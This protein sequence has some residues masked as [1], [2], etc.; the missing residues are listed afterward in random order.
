MPEGHLLFGDL[1]NNVIRK[2]DPAEGDSI[3]RTRTGYAAADVPPGVAMGS[4]GMTLD[5]HGR[6]TICESGNRRVT[7]M[8]PDGT[9]R[10]LADRYE[11]KRLNSPNDLVYRSD[12]SLYFTDPPHG[13]PGEDRD[14]GKELPFNGFYRVAGG[15]I[16]LLSGELTRPNGIAFSPDETALY[17]TNSDPRKKIWTR[18]EVGPDG[19]IHGG[20]IFLDLTRE[21]GQPPDGMKVDIRGNLYLTGPGG[22]WIVSASGKILGLVRTEMEPA[23]CAW[24]GSD[25]RTLYLTAHGDLYRIRL[26]IPGIRPPLLDRTPG[27]G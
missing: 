23:N 8:E 12:G 2:W 14:P 22:L 13:L 27:V 5:R 17:V 1:P 3:V 21:P 16:E 4:N 11:G 26:A 19:G 18:Y 15:R 20:T 24:G 6:L 25:G 10:V 7:L 9:I